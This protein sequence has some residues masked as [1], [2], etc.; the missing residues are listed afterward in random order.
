MSHTPSICKQLF[1]FPQKN[2]WTIII[3]VK[4]R[5]HLEEHGPELFTLFIKQ[6]TIRAQ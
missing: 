2:F 3:S 6:R 1:F 5:Y 4:V